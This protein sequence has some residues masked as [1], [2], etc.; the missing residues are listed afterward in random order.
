MAELALPQSLAVYECGEGRSALA[1]EVVDSG[2]A[3]AEDD[4]YDYRASPSDLPITGTLFV[5]NKVSGEVKAIPVSQI[6]Q[7]QRESKL[8]EFSPVESADGV[9]LITNFGSRAARRLVKL[10]KQRGQ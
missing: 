2:P 8:G 10:H 4:I 9:D 1:F 3:Q 7:I 5:R 6:L